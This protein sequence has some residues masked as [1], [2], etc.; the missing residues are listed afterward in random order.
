MYLIINIGTKFYSFINN[1]I[2]DEWYY[3]KIETYDGKYYKCDQF[4]NLISL[5]KKIIN[6]KSIQFESFS[7]NKDICDR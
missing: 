1:K 6:D 7:M 4:E 3:V 2:K 5:V